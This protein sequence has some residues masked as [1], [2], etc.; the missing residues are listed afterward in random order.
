MT[1]IVS[2]QNSTKNDVIPQAKFSE[3]RA[4]ATAY[5]ESSAA[6]IPTPP[7]M[8]PQT[9]SPQAGAAQAT[10][11]AVPEFK[12][13]MEGARDS[14][15]F[16]VLATAADN[17]LKSGA[18]MSIPFTKEEIAAA[19]QE[20]GLPPDKLPKNSQNNPT[21]LA[22]YVKS[23]RKGAQKHID[24]MQ[25]NGKLDAEEMQSY[26]NQNKDSKVFKSGESGAET[27]GKIIGGI[28]GG[29][30]GQRAGGAIGKKAGG[31]QILP[32][33]SIFVTEKD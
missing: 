14:Y 23:N 11:S 12:P 7:A 25:Q 15:K 27:T 33:P 6:Q 16:R 22:D 9:E 32:P 2:P 1:A 4:I 18:A 26:F 8:T 17:R 28:F 3:A 20:S 24:S 21:A 5:R 13:D 30:L 19:A 10:A 31:E 29:T